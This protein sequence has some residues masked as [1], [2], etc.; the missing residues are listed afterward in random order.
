MPSSGPSGGTARRVDVALQVS[1]S[2]DSA[3]SRPDASGTAGVSRREDDI[4]YSPNAALDIVYP[5]GRIYTFAQGTA[6]YEFYHRN[7]KLN[8]DRIDLT[9]GVGGSLGACGGSLIVGWA[10]GQTRTEELT[11]GFVENV[12]ESTSFAVQAQCAPVAGLT[13]SLGV[14]Y[15]ETENTAPRGVRNSEG[16][17]VNA[18]IGYTNRSL[19]SVA[20]FGSY[21]ESDYSQT[22]VG[23]TPPPPMSPGIK[24]YNAGLQYERPLGRKLLGRVALGYGLVK[25]PGLPDNENLTADIALNYQ[26]TARVSTSFVYRRN[27][28]STF[29]EGTDYILNDQVQADVSYNLSSRLRARLGAGWT[30]RSYRGRIDPR[31]VGAASEEEVVRLSSGLLVS[32]GRRATISLDAQYLDRRTDVPALSYDSIRVGVTASTSF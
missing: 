8:S 4:L 11:L 21:Q 5:V 23:P 28:S 13:A 1:A 10:R 24:T 30:Q 18:S 7:P 2:Y 9:G 17:G 19:G 29:I 16:S 14:S 27:A 22:S 3:V 6:G 32:V 12:Q 31:L 20:L 15:S 25:T 26:P